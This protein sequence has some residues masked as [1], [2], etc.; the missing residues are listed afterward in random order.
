MILANTDECYCLKQIYD[1]DK[2]E[3]KTLK[4]LQLPK[5]TND[6]DQDTDDTGRNKTMILNKRSKLQWPKQVNYNGQNK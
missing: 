4:R 3:N 6:A 1:T 2:N 5:Q